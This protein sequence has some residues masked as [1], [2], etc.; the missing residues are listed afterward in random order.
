MDCA[1]LCVVPFASLR[2]QC[3]A[4]VLRPSQQ[5]L[6]DATAAGRPA[7]GASFTFMTD[8]TLWLER[9]A[10]GQ[11]RELRTAEVLRS[12]VSVRAPSHTPF[13][14]VRDG[15]DDSVLLRDVEG[16]LHV[17]NT[18]RKGTGKLGSCR[19]HPPILSPCFHFIVMY[20]ISSPI[21]GLRGLR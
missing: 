7:L 19:L 3:S 14:F 11:D 10:P 17:S 13:F 20:H 12:R 21:F 6:N 8:V 9:A 16:T 4:C 18:A 2:G 15:I 5:V 1:S